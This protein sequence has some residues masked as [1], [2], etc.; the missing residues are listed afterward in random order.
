MKLI[1]IYWNAGNHAQKLAQAEALR[2]AR[3]TQPLDRNS[4]SQNDEIVHAIY[5]SGA[6]NERWVNEEQPKVVKKCE[7]VGC[8]KAASTVLKYLDEDVDPC[9]NFYEF[10]CGNYLRDTVIP[11]DKVIVFVNL[12]HQISHNQLIDWLFMY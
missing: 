1:V 3:S 4:T 9:D 5:A 11:E 8:V 12:F 7:T 10:A 2:N 6:P